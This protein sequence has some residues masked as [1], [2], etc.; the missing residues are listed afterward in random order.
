MPNKYI[1][2]DSNQN[3]TQRF[4]SYDC[5]IQHMIYCVTYNKV[6]EDDQPSA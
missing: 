2:I 3:Q 4:V 5:D 6:G 1:Y